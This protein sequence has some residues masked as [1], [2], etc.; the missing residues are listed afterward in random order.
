MVLACPGRQNI[1]SCH[2]STQEGKQIV[3][4]MLLYNCNFRLESI[5]KWLPLH[6]YRVCQLLYPK[7]WKEI[8]FHIFFFILV[9]TAQFW[10]EKKKELG[11]QKNILQSLSLRWARNFLTLHWNGNEDLNKSFLCKSFSSFKR[12]V[13]RKPFL[14]RL[15][16]RP[17][18]KFYEA[19][20]VLKHDAK[21]A[22]QQRSIR[23]QKCT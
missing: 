14:P 8:L 11:Q 12:K 5:S 3:P 23:M 18:S 6:D 21:F 17:G 1:N 9:W 22:Y 20:K 16:L 13:G 4:W 15:L 7:P 19:I 2:S 10:R